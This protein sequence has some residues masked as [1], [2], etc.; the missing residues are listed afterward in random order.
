[1]GDGMDGWGRIE[2]G[3]REWEKEG[4]KRECMQHNVLVTNRRICL[5]IYLSIYLSIIN[6]SMKW[7]TL[8]FTKLWKQLECIFFWICSNKKESF[9]ILLH[10]NQVV[11]A[12]YVLWTCGINAFRRKS[13]HFSLPWKTAYK[14]CEGINRQGRC[15][16]CKWNGWQMVSLAIAHCAD[17][18]WR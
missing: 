4:E 3:G 16:R 5:S 13:Q 7:N 6:L 10:I 8:L 15:W 18:G 11:C 9:Q 14:K 1:M 12:Q 17:N 2:E